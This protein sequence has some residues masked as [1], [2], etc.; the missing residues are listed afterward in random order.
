MV[1]DKGQSQI[2]REK[3]IIEG[4]I[5]AKGG[6]R[7]GAG[8][9]RGSTNRE[10]K[11]I[12]SKERTIKERVTKNL[13]SLI[14]AQ[15]TLAK[16]QNFLYEIHMRNVGGK[17]KPQHTLVTD[18]KKIKA[19]MDGD[20]DEDH[21][22]Y[23]TTKEPDGKAIEN[24]LDRAF[25]KSTTNANVDTNFNVNIMQYEQINAGHREALV[26]GDYDSLPVH[27]TSVSDGDDVSPS[28]IQDSGMAQ[29]MREDE[30]GF[31]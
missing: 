9:P 22:F 5:K 29:T 14:N 18:P 16:G 2:D 24:L 12:K 25:G 19:Y 3:E 23:V 1:N 10:T 30:D 26:E 13:T 4:E 11:K 27:S 21:F 17:R 31:K 20:Y 7:P 6:Y 28:E 15:L 8:R